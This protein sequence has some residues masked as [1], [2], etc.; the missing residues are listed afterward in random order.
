MKSIKLISEFFR[1]SSLLQSV[2]T[3]QRVLDAAN[4]DMATLLRELGNSRVPTNRRTYLH[5]YVVDRAGLDH[6]SFLRPVCNGYFMYHD[7][8]FRGSSALSGREMRRSLDPGTLL[9]PAIHAEKRQAWISSSPPEWHE[10]LESALRD[11]EPY[12]K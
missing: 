5:T 7:D 10:W 8:M 6:N 3:V 4:H 12:G 11:F 9:A 2:E 1:S